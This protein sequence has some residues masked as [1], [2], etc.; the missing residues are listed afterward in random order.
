[1][2][3]VRWINERQFVYYYH[4]FPR[5]RVYI[6]AVC[7]VRKFHRALQYRDIRYSHQMCHMQK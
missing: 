3:D 7:C 5:E 6:K 2:T 1:M 4:V